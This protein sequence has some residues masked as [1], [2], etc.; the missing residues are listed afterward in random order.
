LTRG[1]A[2]VAEIATDSLRD[3]CTAEDRA[4]RTLK[5]LCDD[6]AALGGYLY[7]VGDSGLTLVASERSGAEPPAGLLEYVQEYFEREVSEDGD[8]TAA[9][10]G[11]EMTA[12]G[13]KPSFRDSV[14]TDHRPVLMT[15]LSGGVPRHAGVA[16]FVEDVRAERPLGGAELVAAL[17]THLIQSGDTRGVAA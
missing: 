4:Q 15:S 9:L 11:P 10:T 16:V 5:L 17:S 6:R 12:L 13:A 7:L 1:G 8:H 14:G 2:S 3:A